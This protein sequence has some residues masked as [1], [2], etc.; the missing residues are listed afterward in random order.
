MAVVSVE[1]GKFKTNTHFPISH[2]RSGSLHASMCSRVYSHSFSTS[3][4]LV[5]GPEE[6]HTETRSVLL[7]LIFLLISV[8]ASLNDWKWFRLIY[9]VCTLI[10]HET[11]ALAQRSFPAS[12]CNWTIERRQGM[13]SGFPFVAI[14]AC[15]LIF[16]FRELN[17]TACLF[18]RAESRHYLRDYSKW[19]CC[20]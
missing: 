2:W 9:T 16:P 17:Y 7:T 10:E 18:A 8:F 20:L 1:R 12:F 4:L 6:P 19:I 14:V 5:L 11:E 15:T 13:L 3:L